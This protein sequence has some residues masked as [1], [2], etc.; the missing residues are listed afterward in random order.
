MSNTKTIGL[1]HVPNKAI[2]LQLWMTKMYINFTVKSI[3][4]RGILIYLNIDS[5]NRNTES[6]F[7]KLKIF[8][9]VNSNLT[10]KRLILSE[11][12]ET[13]YYS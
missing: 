10:L 8:Q 3:F 11:F 9:Y 7:G 4:W 5:I 6:Y 2:L 12:L 13:I 1:V